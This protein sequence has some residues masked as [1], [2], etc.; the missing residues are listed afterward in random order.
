[1][2][3][4]VSHVYTDDL[5]TI[6]ASQEC[7]VPGYLVLRLRPPDASLPGL[8]PTTAGRLGAMLAAAARAIELAV[9][10]ERV[11]VLS[12]CEVEPRLHF[13]LFPRTRWLLD[14]FRAATGA[15]LGPPS[16]PAL[17]E[18]ARATFPPGAVLPPGVPAAGDA[19]ARLRGLLA[20]G[21]I[22]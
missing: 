10:A 5:V 8:D 15:G 20:P 7:A 16:G 4:P 3:T 22:R 17:F 2:A 12:F 13:H 9:G 1:M 21:G 14:A 19:A 11:Y 6:E 18:W